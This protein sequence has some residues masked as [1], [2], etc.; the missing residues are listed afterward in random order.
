MKH[1]IILLIFCL[2]IT[3]CAPEKKNENEG[4]NQKI[5]TASEIS[6]KIILPTS[7]ESRRPEFETYVLAAQDRIENFATKYRWDSLGTKSYFDSVMVFDKK[8]EFDKILL[9]VTDSDPTIHLPKTYSAALEKRVLMV[10]SPEI[11]S[12]NYPEGIEENSY[13]KLITH[14]IAHRLHI[15]I[16][17][18]NEDLM[19]PIWF[20]EGFAIYAADQ[21]ANS[22]TALSD[23]ELWAIIKTAER[24]SY[25]KYGFI[26]RHFT[27]SIPLKTMINKAGEADFD[28]WLQTKTT[29]SKK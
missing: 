9:A 23:D 6:F 27:H 11:Y 26:F 15:R 25:E 3:G 13:E 29:A 20:Y 16:L 28:T 19:G 2:T 1:F 10:V 22:K 18:N 7:L 24:G 8:E 21:F 14:E 5:K 4:V 17:N 12:T